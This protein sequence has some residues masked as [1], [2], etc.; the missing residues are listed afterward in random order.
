PSPSDQFNVYNHLYVDTGPSITM[1]H[2]HTVHKI[3]ASPKAGACGQK[4][5]TPARFDMVF[6]QH[7][8]QSHTETFVANSV[9]V[10]QVQVIFNLPHHL[11]SYPHPLAYVE[12]F[13]ALQQHNPVS[14]LYI[15]TH[16]T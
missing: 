1:G 14:G 11:G 13:T 15:I 10:A 7:G 6:V 12:W 9:Q 2:A 16:S 8:E 4:V 3:H 5:Q